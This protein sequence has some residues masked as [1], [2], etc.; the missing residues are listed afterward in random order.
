M[1]GMA[2]Y[3]VVMVKENSMYVKC[4]YFKNDMNA[5]AGREYTFR[6]ELPLIPY[7]KVLVPSSDG[8]LKKALVTEINVPESEIQ[9][10]WADRIKEIKEIDKS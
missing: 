5:Y 3:G 8:E 7:Q 10:E 4:I 6:T 1:E 2:G 9:K